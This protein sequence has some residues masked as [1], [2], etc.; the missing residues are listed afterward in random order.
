MLRKTGGGRFNPKD[1]NIYFIAGNPG[2]ME[3][4]A[5]FYPY[6]LIAVNELEDEKSEQIFDKL[7]GDCT[8]F[9]DS[10]VFSLASEY[11]T[12]NKVSH[13]EAL[14]VP[15]NKLPG[16]EAL[17]AKYVTLVKKYETRLWGYV[18][19][20][21]GGAEQKRKTRT[22][23]EGLG[24]RPIPVYHPLNDGWD[25]FDELASTYD[26]ICVGN[27]VQASRYIRKRIMATIWERKKK[28]PKLWVHLLGMTPNQWANSYPMESMDSS[29]W[30]RS[31]R[32][33]TSWMEHV[34]LASF[35]GFSEKYI[36]ILGDTESW[37]QAKC[38]AAS[39]SWMNLHNWK[40]YLA[41]QKGAKV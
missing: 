13:D 14:K 8:V 26:R 5:F 15:L 28:Y 11:A 12:K 21:L 31:V 23:L 3:I 29:S 25:Y 32:W 18:E 39:Q 34:N 30:L 37:F 6:V 20:D 2:D 16:F 4:G 10:G 36:Y 38:V 40:N 35:S 33:P 22:K 7:A 1:K 17:F 27:I 41:A 9:L 19:I 24:L